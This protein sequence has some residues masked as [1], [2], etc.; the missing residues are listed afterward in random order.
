MSIIAVQKGSQSQLPKDS[1]ECFTCIRIVRGKQNNYTFMV[2][3]F[4]I[5]KSLYL[6]GERFWTLEPAI[7]F[8]KMPQNLKL[9][10]TKIQIN[11]AHWL[12]SGLDLIFQPQL[13]LKLVNQ[14]FGW[15]I[16][17]EIFHFLVWS[18]LKNQLCL[19]LLVFLKFF[20]KKKCG[21]DCGSESRFLSD[22]KI[23]AD[24]G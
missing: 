13:R 20:L 23:C 17:E 21:Y 12:W 6:L 22:K 16:F 2:C 24:M 1:L 18:N 10:C 7:L 9:K 11:I 4:S 3:V 14:E 5:T 15:K 19:V 8:R